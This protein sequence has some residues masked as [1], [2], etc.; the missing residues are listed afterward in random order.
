MYEFTKASTLATSLA[1]AVAA[2]GRFP[3]HELKSMRISAIFGHA[4]G[5]TGMTSLVPNQEAPSA[6]G[7]AINKNAVSAL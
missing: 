5:S 7:S 4:S 1:S 3:S 2:S 6:G